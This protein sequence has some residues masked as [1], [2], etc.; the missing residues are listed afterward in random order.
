MSD[1]KLAYRLAFIL[2]CALVGVQGCMAADSEK[3]NSPENE[4]CNLKVGACLN[5]CYKGDRGQRCTQCCR[6]N[7][8]SCRSGQG[9]KF[10]SCR[11]E[12]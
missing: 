2:L 8:F 4:E 7:G 6:Q 5:N 12:E 1:M 9:Y 10:Y 3:D 11:D